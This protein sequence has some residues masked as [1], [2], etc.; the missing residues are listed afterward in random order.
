MVH[1]ESIDQKQKKDVESGKPTPIPWFKMVLDQQVVTDDIVNWHYEGAG[2]EE[3]P[4]IVTW[5]DDDPRNPMLFAQWQ[6]WCLTELVAMATLAVAF[7]SSAYS[8]GVDQIIEQ[9]HCSSEIVVLGISLFVLG[10]A[11]GPLMW[12]PL[13]GMLEGSCYSYFSNLKIV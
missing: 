6:K 9:F 2:T 3:N 8:G 4:Y 7:V 13:S 11:V 5:I 1:G 12:A 10:F